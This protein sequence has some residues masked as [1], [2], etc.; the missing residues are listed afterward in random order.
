MIINGYCETCKSEYFLNAPMNCC[1]DCTIQKFND[2]F[3]ESFI[4]LYDEIK[5][6]KVKSK[7]N[8][9]KKFTIVC[10]IIFPIY[11]SINMFFGWKVEILC[12]GIMVLGQLFNDIYNFLYDKI[13]GSK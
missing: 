4:K 5:I 13:F 8:Y 2:S 7:P 9:I 3:E 10:L 1:K 12:M 11:F 6:D